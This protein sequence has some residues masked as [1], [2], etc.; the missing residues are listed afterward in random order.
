MDT[1]A[2]ITRTTRR[3]AALCLLLLIALPFYLA[4]HWLLPAEMWLDGMPFGFDRHRFGTWPPPPGKQALGIAITFLPG[5]FIALVLYRLRQL[6]STYS[7][8]VYFSARVIALYQGIARCAFW[9][10]LSWILSGAALSLAMSWDTEQRMMS[11]SFSHGHAL[12]LFT[13]VVLRVIAWVMQAGH[14]L[15]TENQSFV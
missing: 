10:V 1:R 6:F 11:L 3:C 15:E 8:G 2:R 7:Q 4:H 13:A 5:L 14:E 9:F 12:A